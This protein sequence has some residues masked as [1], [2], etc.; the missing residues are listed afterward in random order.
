MEKKSN[1]WPVFAAVMILSVI[2]GGLFAAYN[3]E[4]VALPGAEL[5]KSPVIKYISTEM[6]YKPPGLTTTIAKV[7]VVDSSGNPV[8]DAKVSLEVKMPKGEIITGAYTGYANG[9]YSFELTIPSQYRGSD[10]TATATAVATWNGMSSALTSFVKV[11]GSTG[12]EPATPTPSPVPAPTPAPMPLPVEPGK[13]YISYAWSTKTNSNNYIYTKVID[14]NGNAATGAKV[15]G[16]VS[17]G[18]LGTK[19]EMEQEGSYYVGKLPLLLEDTLAK[20][21]VSA[22]KPGYSSGSYSGEVMLYGKPPEEQKDKLTIVDIFTSKDKVMAKILNPGGQPAVGANVKVS[23]DYQGRNLVSGYM[24]YNKQTGYFEY[25]TF[26]VTQSDITATAYV[27]A[28]QGSH[29]AEMKKEVLIYGTGV[30]EQPKAYISAL[31]SDQNGV[32]VK[33]VKSD[34]NAATPEEGYSVRVLI[35]PPAIAFNTGATASGGSAVGAGNSVEKK[36]RTFIGNVVAS[37]AQPTVANADARAESYMQY[38]GQT[39]YWFYKTAGL[40]KENTQMGVDTSLYQNGR[41][42]TQMSRVLTIYG[43]TVIERPREVLGLTAYWYGKVNQRSYD[44]GKTWKTDPDGTSGADIYPLDYCQK[45]FPKATGVNDIGRMYITGWKN[46]GNLDDFDHNGVVYQCTTDGRVN[47]VT[48]LVEWGNGFPVWRYLDGN[49]EPA[50]QLKVID[51]WADDRTSNTNFVWAKVTTSDG[52]PLTDWEGGKVKLT[53]KAECVSTGSSI[54]CPSQDPQTVEMSYDASRGYWR[55][56]IANMFGKSTRVEATVTAYAANGQSATMTKYLAIYGTGEDPIPTPPATHTLYLYRGWN[57][58]SA[59]DDGLTL[60]K[61][62]E[63]CAVRSRLWYYDGQQYQRAQQVKTNP[64][65]TPLVAGQGYWVRVAEDCSVETSGKNFDVGEIRMHRGWN[66]F[67]TPNEN[68]PIDEYAS[69]CSVTGGPWFYN[70]QEREYK[71]QAAI[72]SF[73][74]EAGAGYWLKVSADCSLVFG[75]GGMPPAPPE[76]TV[77]TPSPAPTPTPVYDANRNWKGGANAKV[78]IVEFS[79][80]QCPFCARAQGFLDSLGGQYG[81]RLKFVYRHFP[82]SSIHPDAQKAAE[83][84]ECAAEQGR[85]WQMHDVIFENQNALSVP[86]LK[87]YAKDVGMD[88][89]KFNS[90]LDSGRTAGVVAFD[91]KDGEKLGV[92]GTPYFFINGQMVVGADENGLKTAV[93]KAFEGFGG[94][95]VVAPACSSTG[96]RTLSVNGASSGL[97]GIGTLGIAVRLADVSS[98]SGPDN[99]HAAIVDVLNNNAV[100]VNQVSIDPNSKYTGTYDGEEYTIHVYNTA[101]G[102]DIDSKWAEMEVTV[103]PGTTNAG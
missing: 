61:I 7:Y 100:V 20:V 14:Q 5:Q 65:Y 18:G 67:G 57:M 97:A 99:K 88:T 91:Q 78:T 35:S 58:I 27:S 12:V 6:S 56:N 3:T 73:T 68:L 95:G 75:D 11:Y 53:M 81:N 19:I 48:P 87:E 49:V 34:G 45:W 43:S 10:S 22:S 30:I 69:T 64:S 71:R 38:N 9:A 54:T 29:S 23:I 36:L 82:L 25:P 59:P 92:Q 72:G 50:S 28:Y 24:Q 62:Q 76:E 85:F 79:D 41:Y 94:S 70:T 4:I 40:V 60:E 80:F 37:S 98:A 21:S 74:P 32:Y 26:G 8:K 102:F 47:I 52:V 15:S 90:C 1:V 86:D 84:S 89:A 101:A 63:S 51:I 42:V 55:Y 83:A 93:K 77:I 13:I 46:R 33:A 44:G 16:T 2:A 66:Q 96:I 39:G 31:W 17:Y 103:C